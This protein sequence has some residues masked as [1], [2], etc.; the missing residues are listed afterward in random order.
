MWNIWYIADMGEHAT[1]SVR[2]VRDH[3][4]NVVDRA[5]H[6]EPTVIT[7]RGQPVAAVV[8]VGVLRRYQVLE[9]AELNRIIDERMADP[10]PGIPMEHVMAETLARD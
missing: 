7:R 8:S 2:E 6:D 10:E 5:D 3:L 9:E 1:A 4:A